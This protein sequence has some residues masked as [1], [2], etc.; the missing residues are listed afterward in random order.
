MKT[1]TIVV[2]LAPS[3]KKHLELIAE[4]Q[5]MT[6]SHVIR[7]ACEDYVMPNTKN[8]IPIVGTIS[9]KGI[10]WNSSEVTG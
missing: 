6:L 3:L 9:E 10:E 2:R 7:A 8:Y 1:E 4:C 5:E